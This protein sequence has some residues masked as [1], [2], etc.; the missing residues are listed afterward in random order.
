MF[1]VKPLTH[2]VEPKK[3]GF[4]TGTCI[5]CYLPT[6]RGFSVS[7]IPET[8]MDLDKAVRSNSNVICEYC[9]T[10]LKDPNFRRKNWVI[11]NGAVRFIDKDEVLKI[12]EK[13]PTPPFA[14]Y[15]IKQGKKHGWI[16]MIYKGV[17]YSTETV[18]IGF[19]GELVTINR[20]EFLQLVEILQNLRRMSKISKE[21]LLRLDLQ[22]LRTLG[23]DNYNMLIEFRSKNELSYEL[24]IHLV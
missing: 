14:I 13:P 22:A 9:Y 5:F 17:N 20:L 1:T 12:L 24:A 10:F 4:R 8:F 23:E 11:M 3:L 16:S 7:E 19:E 6:N 21:S 2:L 15:V 18:T